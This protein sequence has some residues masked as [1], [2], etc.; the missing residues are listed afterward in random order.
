VALCVSNRDARRA[1]RSRHSS[2]TRGRCRVLALPMEAGVQRSYKGGI[3]V[4]HQHRPM[5]SRCAPRPHRAVGH[6]RNARCERRQVRLAGHGFGLRPDDTGELSRRCAA[7]EG[8]ESACGRRPW[9]LKRCARG[10]RAHG[11][12]RR[13][14]ENELHARGRDTKVLGTAMGHER[15]ERHERHGAYVGDGAR[16]VGVNRGR[17]QP[18]VRVTATRRR[19]ASRLREA[20]PCRKAKRGSGRSSEP[21]GS[22]AAVRYS[23]R[24]HAAA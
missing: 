11:R 3:E 13:P 16:A 10:L 17:A 15:H 1:R 14:R 21:F 8:P 23:E 2:A 19:K 6:P 7:P 20:S 24:L 5:A 4:E 12:K 18:V 22:A 9:S